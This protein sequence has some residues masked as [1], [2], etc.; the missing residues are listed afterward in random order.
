MTTRTRM[1]VLAGI[2]GL[3]IPAFLL[4]VSIAYLTA[5]Y[6]AAVGEAPAELGARTIAISLDGKNRVAGWYAPVT[7]NE[8]AVLLLHGIKSNRKSQIERM[9]LFNSEGYAVLAIDLPA[10]G[11]STGSRVTFGHDESRAVIAAIKYLRSQNPLARIAIIGQ[12]LGGATAALAGKDLDADAVVLEAV[13][14]D[15]ETAT[16]NRLHNYLGW[17][18]DIAAPILVRAAS[19]R[20]ALSPQALTPARTIADV[21][22]AVLIIAGEADMRATPAE[23]Q[24]IFKAAHDPKDFWL[25]PG[26]GHVD[27]LHVAPDDYRARVL[28]F[29]R[30]HLRQANASPKQP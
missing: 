21:K 19:W 25:V 22:A 30:Q 9:R 26:A 2:A 3:A 15:I 14:A 7:P 28:P 4:L 13:F 24:R 18:G 8:G 29:L 16:S 27:F 20:L 5:P 17:V 1:L 23:S 6:P 12:S 10:H 11:E